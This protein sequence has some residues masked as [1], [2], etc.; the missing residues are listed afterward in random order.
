M[1]VFFSTSSFQKYSPFH[2]PP[3]LSTQIGR[4]SSFVTA[5]VPAEVRRSFPATF[6]ISG[7]FRLHHDLVFFYTGTSFILR[8]HL[9]LIDS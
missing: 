2:E 8:I 9:R 5:C 1:S 4:R 7:E 6:L 3:L